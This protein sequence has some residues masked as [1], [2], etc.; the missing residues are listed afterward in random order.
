MKDK[1]SPRSPIDLY[2]VETPFQLLGAYEAIRHFGVPYR[3]FIRLSGVGRNDEQLQMLA[4]E[5]G[6]RVDGVLRIQKHSR[7]DLLLEVSKCCVRILTKYNRIFVGSYFSRAL[8]L[9][10]ALTRK[11]DVVFLDDGVA[12]YLVQEQ[13][14]KL[15]RP[16]SLF[17][18]F[19]LPPIRDQ[20]IWVH[21]FEA[22][23][24]RYRSTISDGRVFIG[25]NLFASGSITPQAYLKFVMEL[26]EADRSL[27]LIY[28][29]HRTEPKDLLKKIGDLPFVDIQYPA[30]GIELYFL[31]K[32]CV[33]KEFYSVCS[34]AIFSLSAMFPQ[35][36]FFVVSPDGYD[37][38]K[39]PHW[40][41]IARG[42]K[43][44]PNVFF[45]P[46]GNAGVA[47][48]KHFQMIDK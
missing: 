22:L 31:K 14:K 48:V 2:L 45:L 32:G 39:F 47:E 24:E 42:L 1:K 25:Q 13:L 11:R 16:L 19:D 43:S 41:R 35:A 37:P 5:L 30:S 9:I 40:Q 29:P 34:T 38:S 20:R 21:K 28:I 15:G 26:A 10:A 12:T 17:T 27:P 44:I 7:K 36:K 33:P 4:R 46:R 3:L 23:R 18:L 6:V 8:Q